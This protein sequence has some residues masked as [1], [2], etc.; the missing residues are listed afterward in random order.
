MGPSAGTIATIVLSAIGLIVSIVLAI[1]ADRSAQQRRL[2]DTLNELIT[3]RM[4]TIFEIL[5]K[6]TNRITTAE[7]NHARLLGRLEGRGVLRHDGDGE[8]PD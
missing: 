8:V 2:E 1:K 4:D 3:K 5:D 7:L 6:H